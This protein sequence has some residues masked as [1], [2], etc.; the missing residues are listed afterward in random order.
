MHPSIHFC[1]AHDPVVANVTPV[2]DSRFCPK[3]VVILVCPE[4]QEQAGWL[5]NV[6][7]TLGV[8]VKHCV[9][10]DAWDVTHIRT[11]VKEHL[12]TRSDN[13][14]IALNVTG[15]TKPMTVA[16]YEAFRDAGKPIFY[17]H[18]ERDHLVWMYPH[19]I[20]SEDL[21]D[22]IKLPEFLMVHGAE[23]VGS[24]NRNPIEGQWRALTAEL[25]REIEKYAAPLSALNRLA[26]QAE[27]RLRVKFDE[28]EYK[29]DKYPTDLL[30]RIRQLIDLF[31]RHKLF[32]LE[33]G[34]LF[35]TSEKTRFYVNGGWLEEHVFGLLHRIKPDLDAIQKTKQEENVIQDFARNLTIVKKNHGE[36]VKNELDVAL[37]A[38]NKLHII[39][40]KTKRFDF[41]GIDS[42]GAETLY[43]LD[44][45][46]DHIGGLQANAMLVSYQPLQ[47]EHLWRANDLGIEVCTG[48]EIQNLEQKLK[49]WIGGRNR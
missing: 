32:R 8:K 38:D 2:L 21:F 27:R 1:L 3:E 29:K 35:F 45:L 12:A 31:S 26:S 20:P 19:C 44:T 40:C 5:E 24:V 43:K 17:V 7:N 6:L 49:N 10:S 4:R 34:E 41:S 16:A 9:I 11:C 36:P 39:E 48:K 13:E 33:H 42:P 14:E 47:K 30:S 25:I 23:L 22:R 15:G 46:R 28:Y 18:P 37:L